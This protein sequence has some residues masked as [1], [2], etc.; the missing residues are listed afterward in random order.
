ME[1]LRIK[2]DIEDVE[3]MYLMLK[4][5]QLAS[6]G[7]GS[8]KALLSEN[9][10]LYVKVAKLSG[11]IN[12]LNLEVKKLAKQFLDSHFMENTRI[13]LLI[14]SLSP[15]LL[16]PESYYPYIF[17]KSYVSSTVAFND[18]YFC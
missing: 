17:T 15:S 5:N 2:L 8:S 11:K 10:D 7:P 9:A 16:P 18:N 4:N 1:E 13:E 12:E 14:K 6:E 3:L